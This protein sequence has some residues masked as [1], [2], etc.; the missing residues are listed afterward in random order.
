MFED[1][2]YRDDVLRDTK[3][4]T[5]A[6]GSNTS[7]AKKSDTKSELKQQ[8]KLEKLDKDLGLGKADKKNKNSSQKNKDKG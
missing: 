3:E 1:E 6:S 2:D 8:K 5:V 7:S 4:F